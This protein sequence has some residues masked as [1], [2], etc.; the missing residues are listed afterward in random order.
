MTFD[1]DKIRESKRAFRQR[2]A[3]QPVA[4]KLAM[5]DVLRERQIAIRGGAKRPDA[6]SGFLRQSSKPHGSLRKPAAE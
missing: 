4:E 3:A 5:L 2:L 6:S 1:L